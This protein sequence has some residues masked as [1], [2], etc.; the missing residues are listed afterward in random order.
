LPKN[1]GVFLQTMLVTA[2]Q[3]KEELLA[4]MNT[5][6]LRVVIEGGNC[7]TGHVWPVFIKFQ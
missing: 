2:G 5:S 4:G 6:N 7:G 1:Q 3:N